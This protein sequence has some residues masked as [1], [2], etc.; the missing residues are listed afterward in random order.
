MDTRTHARLRSILC[1]LTLAAWTGCA[2]DRRESVSTPKEEVSHVAQALAVPTERG[3]ALVQADGNL[4]FPEA[5][6]F[7]G[8]GGSID[9]AHPSTGLYRVIFRNLRSFA[10]NAQAVALGGGIERCNLT[11]WGPVGEGD[12]FVDV[13]CVQGAQFADSSFVV[14]YDNDMRRS[15]PTDPAPS[16][17]GRRGAFLLSF[18]PSTSGPV[19]PTWSFNPTGGTN[20]IDR[21]GPGAYFVHLP[22]LTDGMGN[23]Q[24]TAFG[25]TSN[26]CHPTGW[27]QVP[28]EVLVGALCWDASGQP[29][30]TAFS[31]RYSAHDRG[32]EQDSRSFAALENPLLPTY[33]P[34]AAYQDNDLAQNIGL[35][36]T[37]V[38]RRGTGSYT[39]TVQQM[40]DRARAVALITA[41]NDSVPR[42]CKPTGWSLGPQGQSTN[43]DVVCFDA[44]GRP[45]DSQLAQL[46]FHHQDVCLTQ[47]CPG[48]ERLVHPGTSRFEDNPSLMGYVNPARFST[49]TRE[50]NWDFLAKG[51]PSPS[52]GETYGGST[53]LVLRSS[54]PVFA[55]PMQR[56]NVTLVR[57]SSGSAV[58]YRPQL[59][60]RMPPWVFFPN[61]CIDRSC[62][63]GPTVPFF[64]SPI[65]LPA[66]HG[67]VWIDMVPE[68]GNPAIPEAPVNG[69]ALDLNAAVRVVPVHAHVLLDSA[70][71]P[72]PN[73]DFVFTQSQDKVVEYLRQAFDFGFAKNPAPAS[74][75]DTRRATV[76]EQ[77]SLALAPDTSRSHL[78]TGTTDTVFYGCG[79]VQ[80][81]LESVSFIRQ[82]MG[83]ERQMVSA[84][85]ANSPDSCRADIEPF[86]RTLRDSAELT[87]KPGLHIVFGGFVGDVATTPIA[88]VS[89]ESDRA[90]L[91]SVAGVGASP[92]NDRYHHVTTS[93]EIGHLLGL[94]HVDQEDNLMHPFKGGTDLIPGQCAE[95]GRIARLSGF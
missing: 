73:Y 26:F 58:T 72:G 93:H 55:G 51:F 62:T 6:S 5:Y 87:M 36:L 34:L 20:S 39:V 11:G 70:G 40:P 83:L 67:L 94:K 45:A 56:S 44:A 19:N 1:T 52:S 82:N 61:D 10:G 74:T 22:G 37:S 15:L 29:A 35:S 30:D 49:V 43:I 77:A 89:C 71:N 23:V 85:Q 88:G 25:V 27:L 68:Q 13:I 59:F 75:R 78:V 14:F 81:R 24:I 2:A 95:V 3:Y 31:L 65:L 64:S 41:I 33:T 69:F 17:L 8:A 63:W 32:S 48:P 47:F 46:F 28:G 92:P 80:F 16:Q 12:T 90:A 54:V 57:P 21:I 53:G 42:F 4:R 38:V 9:A 60:S 50:N 18:D 79:P 7:N 84:F 91:V 76:T 86:V 66:D